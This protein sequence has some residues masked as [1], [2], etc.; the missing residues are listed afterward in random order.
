[1]ETSLIAVGAKTHYEA[2]VEVTSP[3]GSEKRRHS[4]F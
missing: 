2:I 4:N 1:M 3:I